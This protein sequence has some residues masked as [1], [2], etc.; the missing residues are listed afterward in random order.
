MH[1]DRV[2]ITQVIA[3]LLTNAFQ[4]TERGSVSVSLKQEATTV[5]IS[6]ADTGGGMSRETLA[7]VYESFYTTK[8]IGSGTGLGLAFCKAAVA[9]HRGDIRVSSE[10][11]RGTT[12]TVVP[13]KGLP[14]ESAVRPIASA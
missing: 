6:V 4:A 9:S 3:N 12:F 1:V 10:P 2:Q 7:H 8:S 14:S 11:G 13:P 5:R